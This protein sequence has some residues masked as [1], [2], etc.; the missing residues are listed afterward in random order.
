MNLAVGH[1]ECL[2]EDIGH[3][4]GNDPD[5]FDR[6]FAA[7]VDHLRRQVHPIRRPYEEKYRGV[8]VIGIDQKP[9]PSPGRYSF[10]SGMISRSL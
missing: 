8:D 2:N 4:P 5:F 3:V 1:G 7:H 10:R 6:A 9:E